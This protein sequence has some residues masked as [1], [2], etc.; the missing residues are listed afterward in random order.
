[1]AAKLSERE[2]AVLVL[3]GYFGSTRGDRATGPDIARMMNADPARTWNA[4]AAGAHRTAA[5]LVRKGLIRREGT[6]K[7]RWYTITQAGRKALA[8]YEYGDAHSQFAR[9]IA[10]LPQDH[11]L[12][13]N[14]P[15]A[16]DHMDSRAPQ[17]RGLA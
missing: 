12:S 16:R 13:R 3:I 15:E 2:S 14:N 5:S 7:L 4:S 1:M 11:E 9:R 10:A 6:I 17:I 8:G